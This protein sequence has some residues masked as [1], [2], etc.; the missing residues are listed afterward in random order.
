VNEP[1]R[2]A[3]DPFDRVLKILDGMSPAHKP[4]DSEPLRNILPGVWPTLSELRLLVE[5]IKNTLD[6]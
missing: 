6:E 4:P 1:L 3:V 2:K 5:A